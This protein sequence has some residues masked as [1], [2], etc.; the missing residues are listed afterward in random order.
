MAI[1]HNGQVSYEYLKDID[2]NLLKTGCDTEALLHYY[3]IK[4]E[5]EILRKIPGAYTMAI[6]DK[7]RR[8]VIVLKDR[9]GIK[10]G[11]LG[12]KNGKYVVASEEIAFRKNKGKI[13]EDLDPG[14]IYYLSPYGDYTKEHVVESKR[15]L[16]FFEI[17]YLCY[18]DSIIGGVSVRKLRETL[19]E[20]LAKEFNPEDIDI[21]T[22]LPRYPEPA[23]RR[24]SKILEKPFI[25]VFYKLRSERAFQGST[26]DDRK[27]SIE[28]NLHLL[29]NIKNAL[30][31]K[32][33]VSIDDSIVRGNNSV[34]ER[35]LLYDEACVKKCY[36]LSY[37]PQI[38]IIGKDGTPIGCM[39]GV[40]MP[41]NDNFV[42]RGRTRE[43]I[44]DI[45]KIPVFYIS[46]EEMLRAF[47]KVGIS[48]EDL[49]I[50]CIVG[51]HPFK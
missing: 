44:S 16:C 28:Q 46:R 11:A 21:V 33:V 23:A 4:G 8:G 19:G 50:Y 45:M 26:I 2:K 36:H 14:C 22:F 32:T 27:N 6:A 41:P 48:R 7:K 9:T 15:A 43:E 24:F 29:Y 35:A 31:G 39:F 51:K 34:R 37:T 47:E 18:V 1:V 20:E 3:M 40:D 5:H 49:C 25:P 38:G 42:A 13:I 30:R 12:W 17:N 10:S